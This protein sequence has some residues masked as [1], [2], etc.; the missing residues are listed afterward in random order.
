MFSFL[1]IRCSCVKA[2]DIYIYDVPVPR[3]QVADSGSR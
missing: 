2:L 1:L 3:R